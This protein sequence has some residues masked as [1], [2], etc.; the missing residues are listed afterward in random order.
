MS[1]LPRAAGADLAVAGLEAAARPAQ[2]GFGRRVH[3]V[4][5]AAK[6]LRSFWRLLDHAAGGEVTRRRRREL[7]RAARFLAAPRERDALRSLARELMRSEKSLAAPLSVFLRRL[8]PSPPPAS[9]KRKLDLAASVLET[10]SRVLAR[11]ALSA[12]RADLR[13]GFKA[14][15]RKLERV[16][17]RAVRRR[18]A[19][20]L[21]ACRKR[22]KDLQFILEAFDIAPRSARRLQKAADELGS[23]RDLR[24]LASKAGLRDGTLEKKARKLEADALSRL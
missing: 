10:S 16:R 8:A 24:T 17:K 13:K 3:A 14:L 19:A 2:E 12:R 7:S 11:A 9:L 23:A 15:K 6:R 5:V 21:H 1:R 22:A 20:D 4:R 18:A